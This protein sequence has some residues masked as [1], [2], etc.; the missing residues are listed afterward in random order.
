VSDD[1]FLQ[2]E[3]TLFLPLHQQ[4]KVRANFGYL[5]AKFVVMVTLS[6][7]MQCLS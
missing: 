2:A 4:Q 6:A 5:W 3:Q 1:L 7:A